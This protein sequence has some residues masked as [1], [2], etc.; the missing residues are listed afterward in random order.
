MNLNE[1]E[2]ELCS[3]GID[4][5]R[6]EAYLI[7]ERLFG[8]NRASLLLERE[9]DFASAELDTLLKKRKARVPLQ[10]IFGDWE[11]MGKKFYFFM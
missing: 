5:A 8:V 10:Y 4:D 1:L 9:R 11:F 3:Y 6:G 2:R 7:L